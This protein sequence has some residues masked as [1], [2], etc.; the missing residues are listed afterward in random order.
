[1]VLSDVIK[2]SPPGDGIQNNDILGGLW[3]LCLKCMVSSAMGSYLP[4]LEA[5]KGRSNSLEYFGV[6]SITLNKST[7]EGFF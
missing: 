3:A 2:A 1:M 5:T 4:P 7:K 6:S